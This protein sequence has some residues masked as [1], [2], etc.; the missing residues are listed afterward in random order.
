VV[1]LR[2]SQKCFFVIGQCNIR[3][4]GI[5]LFVHPNGMLGAEILHHKSFKNLIGYDLILTEWSPRD[6]DVQMCVFIS[7]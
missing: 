1:S 6:K 3:R 5:P 7:F 2:S 4:F